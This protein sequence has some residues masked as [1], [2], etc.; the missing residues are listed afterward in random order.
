MLRAKYVKYILKFNHPSGTSRGVLY[1][2]PSWFLKIWENKNPEIYGLGECA[3]I[4][5]LSRESIINIEPKLNELCQNIHLHES[6]E[7]D[8][9][10]S[11]KFA[12]EIALKDLY[13]GGEKILFNNPF[14][15]EKSKIKING[16]I[17][18]GEKEHM[19]NQI[20]DKIDLGFSCLK[21]KIGSI[22]FKDELYLIQKIRQ[23]FKEDDLELR[24][25][26][27]GAFETKD[28]LNKLKMLSEY[29]IH[30][31][32][33]PIMPGQLKGMKKLCKESPIDIALD[34]ELIPIINDGNKED[35]IE[36]L[37][38]QYIILKPS[39]LGGFEA[40]KKWITIAEKQNT[41]WWITSA[42]ESNIGLNSIAQFTAE[43][44][45]PLPQ[46]LGTG[47][48]YSN[49][50]PSFLTQDGEHLSIDKNASWKDDILNF[51]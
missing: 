16:L 33:Q 6:I 46:G 7:L 38:P 49:N 2:K 9:F 26:A 21:L 22:D 35:L 20:R 42:L 25:D 47:K 34:E 15:S 10:P 18:M 36:Y 43:F 50:I 28:A 5:G 48:I 8:N 30:S 19:L 31:I 45:N 14:T 23:E 17:W 32:E 13:N 37:H 39:L 40:T 41:S 27:N 29:N 12:L 11:I 51:N 24:V 1:N 44:D 3:P 4:H